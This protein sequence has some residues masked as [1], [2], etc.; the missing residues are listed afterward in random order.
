MCFVSF[1]FVVFL[2]Q[3]PTCAMSV[4]QKGGEWLGDKALRPLK[5]KMKGILLAPE[6][7]TLSVGTQSSRLAGAV[8]EDDW[9]CSD[10]KRT[11]VGATP[12]FKSWS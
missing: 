3:R 7:G 10:W 2:L 8:S 6:I 12:V 1:M 4:D 9:M 11:P 5:R